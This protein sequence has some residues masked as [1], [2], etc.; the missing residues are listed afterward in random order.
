MSLHHEIDGKTPKP[1]GV[2]ARQLILMEGAGVRTQP[3]EAELAARPAV[4][5][6][7]R[8]MVNAA[9]DTIH[10]LT[11]VVG[12]DRARALTRELVDLGIYGREPQCP[13]R[14]PNL[15]PGGR[16]KGD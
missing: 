15:S 11:P 5:R 8:L 6:Y 14:D 13:S 4:E 2:E 7:W 16:E 9:D 10:R 12:L 1:D 3:S